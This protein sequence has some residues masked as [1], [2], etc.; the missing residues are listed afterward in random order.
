MN[1]QL[2]VESCEKFLVKSTSKSLVKPVFSGVYTVVANAGG[3]TV[4][5]AHGS[6]NT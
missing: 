6:F 1:G 2:G 3:V 5:V 4:T